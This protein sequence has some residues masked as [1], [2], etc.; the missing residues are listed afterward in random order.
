MIFNN[1]E[2]KD[3]QALLGQ[4]YE[5]CGYYF[6]AA[7]HYDEALLSANEDDVCHLL[8]LIAI[9]KCKSQDFESSRVY[10]QK[11][12]TTYIDRNDAEG[13]ELAEIYQK[14]GTVGE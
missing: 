3:I 10:L 14:C 5:G 7:R 6:E 12:I 1:I 2:F 8:C 13:A 4:V 11:A 9:C